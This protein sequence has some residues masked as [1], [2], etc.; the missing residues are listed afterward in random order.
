MNTPLVSL[1]ALC[2]A[3]ALPAQT[4]LD[5][6]VHHDFLPTGAAYANL[7]STGVVNDGVV[8]GNVTIAAG[9]IGAGVNLG[10][11]S[12]D[13]VNCGPTPLLG[14]QE[15]TVSVW[16][17]TTATTGIVTP[18]SFGTNPGIGTKWDM[19]IDAANGGVFELGISGGRTTGQGT[20]VNDGQWHMLTAVLPVGATNLNQVRMFVDGA[21]AYTGSGNQTINTT[22]GPVIVGRSAN[23]LTLIQF[24]PGDVDEVV[25]WSVPLNDEQVQGL[26]DVAVDAG[27]FYSPR[28]YEQ[29]LEVCRQNQ[30]EV[31]I[32]TFTWHR[33]TGLTGPAG[34]S[35]LPG[36]GYQLVMDA[37]TG[38][39]IATPAATFVT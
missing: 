22:N 4:S 27:L 38:D 5:Y 10:G 15:R 17:R 39:G 3:I 13:E 28:E 8:Q 2:A 23:P 6:Q 14:A 26:H 34:L 11:A 12:G 32:G 37:M 29:L 21:L 20:A 7:G 24:F 16:V 35:V 31:T 33:A 18:L 1:A 30:P 9:A 36:G 25:L 19:D